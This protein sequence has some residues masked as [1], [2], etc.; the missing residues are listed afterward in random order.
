[1]PTSD[2]LINYKSVLLVDVSADEL[3]QDQVTDLSN[4]T[5]NLG[6]G[7]V[8]VGGIQ[9]YGLGGYLNSDLE[10]LLPVV[11][12]ILDPRRRQTV[13]QVLAVDTSG[14]MGACHCSEGQ[15]MGNQI[16][17]GVTKTDIARAGAARAIDALTQNDEVGIL[18]VDTE[19]E[20]VMDLQALPS[21]EVITS[22]LRKLTPS[23]ESTNLSTALQTA[24][25]QLRESHTSLKHIILFTDGFVN[26][27]G[28]FDDLAEQAAAL[29]EEGITV[30]VLATG[31][32]A[33]AQLEQVASAG[34]GRFYPGRDLQEIPQL[35]QQEAMIASRDFVN[36]GEFP[37][38][39]SGSS[40]LM[41]DFTASPPLLG[42]IATTAKEQ[43]ETH[44]RIGP[45]QD[46][47]LASWNV[48]LGRVT[49]WM[50][51]GGERWAQTWTSWDGYVNFWSGVVADTFP[52]V[53]D[54]QSVT[55]RIENGVLKVRVEHGTDFAE[56]SEA[57]AEVVGPDR[58][59]QELRLERVGAGAFAGEMPVTAAG[60]YAVGAQV[61]DPGGGS[62]IGGSALASLSYSPEYEP[63][64]SDPSLLLR[65]S[66]ITSGRGSIRAS[67]AFD[68][69]GLRA[70]RSR[71]PLARW[72]LL[73]AA[74]L[75]PVAVALSRLSLRGAVTAQVR[76]A[77]ATAVWLV[78]SRVKVPSRPSRNEPLP[79]A[80][81]KPERPVVPPRETQADKD[82]RAKEA[83]PA[84]SIGS[85]LASQRRRKGTDPEDD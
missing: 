61:T 18:A 33:A 54:S 65:V 83:A 40:A 76:H 75:W 20:W 63:G 25:A 4:A 12:D 66:E 70:G 80:P 64:E 53:S 32:G 82:R 5:R 56:G 58:V 42:Y 28:A 16:S 38:L 37:P 85:L 55:A 81:P 39:V 26:E 3:T 59:G 46:P 9:S 34:G 41:R 8:T 69:D 43:T 31:E 73:A 36:E 84:A 62:P 49:S 21:E 17:G 15:D 30:S 7:L 57:Q 35:M 72:F 47:L 22:G 68:P 11:S 27:S 79:P 52:R 44:L 2:E 10:Q 1:V 77:G 29:R 71:V 74:L 50:S 67:A 23:G 51:D 78:R 13:A 24:A 6:V 48:G 14:S 45:D 60:V 19:D